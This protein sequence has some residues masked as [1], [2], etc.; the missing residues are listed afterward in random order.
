MT[1]P[2][3]SFSNLVEYIPVHP[4][5]TVRPY[6]KKA[7]LPNIFQKPIT[8][9]LQKTTSSPSILSR[10][11]P[12]IRLEY[13]DNPINLKTELSKLEYVNLLQKEVNK[14]KE[15]LNL[16]RINYLKYSRKDRSPSKIAAYEA[17][18]IAEYEVEDACKAWCYAQRP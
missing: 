8:N 7:S 16:A 15:K 17:Y 18:K 10:D 6:T 11:N 3:H 1:D 13:G 4:H 9:T 5:F 14:A 2:S 12:K